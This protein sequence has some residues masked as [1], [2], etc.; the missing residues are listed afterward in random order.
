MRPVDKAHDIGRDSGNEWCTVDLRK[1][2]DG[3][4]EILPRRMTSRRDGKSVGQRC[5]TARWCSYDDL[6]LVSMLRE[7]HGVGCIGQVK[8][9]GR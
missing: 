5:F 2:P 3:D 1:R 8:D 7:N 9:V 6:G 4:V